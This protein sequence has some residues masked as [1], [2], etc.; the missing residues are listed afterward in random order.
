[1][2]RPQGTQK[3]A[4]ARQRHQ[5]NFGSLSTEVPRLRLQAANLPIT[6]SKPEMISRLKA[7]IQP[8]TSQLPSSGCVQKRT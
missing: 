3:I 5:E 4:S 8:R 6:G 2:A 7:T 1:M